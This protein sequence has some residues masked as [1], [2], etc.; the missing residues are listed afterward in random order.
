MNDHS[1]RSLFRRDFLRASGA[2]MTSLLT[3]QHGLSAAI[4]DEKRSLNGVVGITTGGGLGRQRTRGELNLLTL[5]GYMRDTLGLQLI[6]VNTRWF[7]SY[8]REYLKGIRE[9]AD[10]ADCFYTN[11][12]VND[13]VSGV[14]YSKD[15]DKR[16]EAHA[17]C[18]TL[19]DSA[20][21][22]G[23]RWIRFTVPQHA[24]KAPVAHRELAVYAARYGI[25]LLVE[26]SG[27]LAHDAKSI[28]AIA[29]A[30]GNKAAPCPDTGNWDDNLRP[31]A[32]RNSFPN[33][34]SCDFKVWELDAAHHH[35]GTI[36][37]SASTSA[38]RQAIAVRG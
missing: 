20:K 21:I 8:D 26:N 14:L 3:T 29:K 17:K 12:K 34:V 36:L 19:I 2:G 4:K 10:A 1:D 23:A 28:P 22:L 11:L 7:D 27:W 13:P 33:A 32:L 15:A 30:I 16:R 35:A 24:A 38:G 9:A 6:D 5:P 31:Q 25:Q 18:R 37:S